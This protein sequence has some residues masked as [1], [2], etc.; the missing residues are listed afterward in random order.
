MDCGQALSNSIRQYA[1]F[2]GRASRSEFWWFNVFVALAVVGSMLLVAFVAMTVRNEPLVEVVAWLP[3]A[4]DLAFLL[5]LV[6]VSCRR[7][8][9][10]GKSGWWQLLL[11]TGIGILGLLVW[12]AQESEE[13]DN[14]YGPRE[15][16]A[17]GRVGK[18]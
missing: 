9:D 2:S 13:A 18:S 6:T 5:P 12:F 3:L 4:V 8:H 7:L 14:R 15:A 17:E 16:G 1:K 11:L 10:T